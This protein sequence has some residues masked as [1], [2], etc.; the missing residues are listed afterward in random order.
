MPR[1]TSN[2]QRRCHQCCVNE[3]NWLM[4]SLSGVLECARLDQ[5]DKTKRPLKPCG[6]ASHGPGILARLMDADRAFWLT[7]IDRPHEDQRR[8]LNLVG[9]NGSRVPALRRRH[10]AG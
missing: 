5:L 1:T 9:R 4:R 2:A 7:D 6:G 8:R 3:R 10:L